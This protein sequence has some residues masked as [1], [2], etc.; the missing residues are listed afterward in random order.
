[1]DK[2]ATSLV[3]IGT[4]ADADEESIF[5]YHLNQETGSVWDITG[6][7]IAGPMKGK[8]LRIEP[9]SNHLAFAWLAFYPES[10]IYKEKEKGK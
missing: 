4:Y 1:M 6:R 3:Y 5:L 7:S 2:P 10:E 8:Q 9:H